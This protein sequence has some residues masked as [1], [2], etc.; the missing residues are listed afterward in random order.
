MIT[1][2][3]SH[4]QV[5]DLICADDP[6]PDVIAAMIILKALQGDMNALKYILD[7]SPIN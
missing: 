6:E 7:N 4:L 3:F 2:V 5:K 1:K